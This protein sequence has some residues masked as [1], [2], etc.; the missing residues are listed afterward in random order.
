MINKNHYLSSMAVGIIQAAMS[1]FS[2]HQFEIEHIECLKNVNDPQ[3]K[4]EKIIVLG[5]FFPKEGETLGGLYKRFAEYANHHRRLF[6]RCHIVLGFPKI[7][8]AGMIDFPP[9]GK[10]E[11]HS[12]KTVAGY[13]GFKMRY[14]VGP[15]FERWQDEGWEATIDQFSVLSER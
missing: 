7:E 12:D 6:P 8:N 15:Q 11:Y 4:I 9:N 2:G 3:E 1:K 5:Y 14:V 13:A 10:I